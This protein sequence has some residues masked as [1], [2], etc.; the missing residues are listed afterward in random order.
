GG[1]ADVYSCQEKELN[2]LKQTGPAPN[3]SGLRSSDRA[4]II[5]ACKYKG[6]PADVYNCQKEQLNKLL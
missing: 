5:G 1:P 3:L 6:S 4:G 2:K